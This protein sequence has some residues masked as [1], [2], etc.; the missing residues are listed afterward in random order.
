MR[1]DEAVTYVSHA[2]ARRVRA[3]TDPQDL[4]ALA[5]EGVSLP[6]I[7]VSRDSIGRLIASGSNYQGHDNAERMPFMCEFLNRRVLPLID[8]GVDVT[9]SYRIEL[10]DSYSYL[11]DRWRYRNALVFTRPASAREEVALIPD[12]YHIA[13]FSGLLDE[14]RRDRE[15]G[16]PFSSRRDAMVFAGTTTGD[17]DPRRNARVQA[18][19]WALDRGEHR[20]RFYITNIAQMDPRALMQGVPRAGDFLRAPLNPSDQFQH[21]FVV[22]IA[23]NTACWSR[24]PMVLASGSL[25]VNLRHE[26]IMWY[27]PMLSDDVHYVAADDLD[28]LERERQQLAVDTQRCERLIANSNAFAD[29]F[30]DPLVADAY[31]AQLLEASAH[32]SRA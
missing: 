27:Y 19:L 1:V 3:I 26:D 11:K 10:H 4:D 12:P 14:S 17:R 20:A 18:C 2:E 25:L 31:M 9:G 6:V 29:A 30:F 16:T 15:F 22:N 24:L 8:T 7:R 32:H 23:G 21:K 28:G 5:E 13:G